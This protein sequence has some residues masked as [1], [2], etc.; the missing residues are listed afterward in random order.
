LKQLQ[1]PF[2]ECGTVT[3]KFA[4]LHVAQFT[5]AYSRR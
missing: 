3:D 4:N 2:R 1:P 5:S